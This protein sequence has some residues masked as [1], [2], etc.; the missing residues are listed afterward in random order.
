MITTKPR[1]KV[2]VHEAKEDLAQAKHH[3][4]G[5]ERLRERI[6]KKAYELYEGRG[7]APGHDMDDWLE[8]EKIV[9]AEFDAGAL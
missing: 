4:E 2:I 3:F 8:A 7:C 9:A 5:R 1:H 6:E